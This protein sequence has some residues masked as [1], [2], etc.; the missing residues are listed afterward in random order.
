DARADRSDLRRHGATLGRG[1]LPRRPLLRGRGRGPGVAGLAP[2]RRRRELRSRDRRQRVERGCEIQ[3]R[4]RT[5]P[6]ARRQFVGAPAEQRRHGVDRPRR[7]RRPRGLGLLMSVSFLSPLA[8]LI[9]LGVAVPLAAFAVVRRRA[10]QAR[11]ALGL[12]EPG[13]RERAAVPVALAAVAALVAVAAAQPVLHD[14]RTRKV[15]TDAEAWAVL[16][17]SRS[18]LARQRIHAPTT[19]RGAN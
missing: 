2:R 9:A 10:A 16:D 6:A 15:R 11:A 5:L 19:L 18:M 14:E 8:A 13:R 4:T 7:G 3:P 12:P 1:E 17:T